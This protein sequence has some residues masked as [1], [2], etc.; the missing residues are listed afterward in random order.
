VTLNFVHKILSPPPFYPPSLKGVLMRKW[1]RVYGGEIIC[2][3]DK[4]RKYL[5]VSFF[6][7]HLLSLFFLLSEFVCLARGGSKRKSTHREGMKTAKA[8]IIFVIALLELFTKVFAERR[9]ETRG[10]IPIVVGGEMIKNAAGLLCKNKLAYY[11]ILFIFLFFLCWVCM[12]TGALT[13][14]SPQRAWHQAWH[15]AL[16]QK[17]WKQPQSSPP[18]LGYHRLLLWCRPSCNSQQF[19]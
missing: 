15:Q 2:Y 13:V 6:L 4:R 19:S 17:K 18:S 14:W 16:P 5:R 12:S 3:G 9:I 10:R 7:L 8:D 1:G 11:F